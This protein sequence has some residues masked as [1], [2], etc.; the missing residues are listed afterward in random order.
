MDETSP[1]AEP[2]AQDAAGAGSPRRSPVRYDLPSVRA[3]KE[4]RSHRLLLLVVRLLF[5][6]LLVTVTILSIASEGRLPGDFGFSTIFGLVLATT[7]IGVIVLVLDAMTPNKRLSSLV[8]VYVGVCFGLIGAFAIGSLLDVVTAAWS[9][10]GVRGGRLEV[11]IG[12]AKVIVGIVLS[13]LAVSVVLTTKDDFR[14]VIPYVEFAKQVR[15]V[16][17]LLLDTSVLIDGRINELGQT[18]FLDAPLVI[19]RFVIDE[20]QALA[21][22]GERPKRARGRRGL[23]MVSK[24]QANPYVDLSIDDVRVDA[25]SVDRSLIE[26]ARDQKLRIVTTDAALKKVAQINGVAVLNINDLANTLKSAAL[27]GETLVVE[28]QK[29]GESEG[30]GVGYLADGT[31]VVIEGAAAFVGTS[32]QASVTNSL[33]T[34]AGRMIFAK[35]EDG[36]P[37]GLGEGQ[38]AVPHLARAATQQ[39]RAPRPPRSGGEPPSGR[40]PRR[41]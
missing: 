11:Y 3:E 9:E 14:L 33:Q 4:E 31:M 6:V 24:L 26:L 39:P 40:N 25:G 34:S 15:G 2:P 41:G 12:L 38:S 35:V 17:P 1:A 18:G 7:S 22:S 10:E 23:D 29:E 27:P 19:P 32:V 37:E 20:L 28:V 36:T 5:V 8:S 21:D 16:R 30:Q 13:Y